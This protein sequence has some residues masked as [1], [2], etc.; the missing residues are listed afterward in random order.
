MGRCCILT[1][2][3]LLTSAMGAYADTLFDAPEEII[4][5]AQSGRVRVTIA[6]PVTQN[7]TSKVCVLYVPAEATDFAF[8]LAGA[9]NALL[10]SWRME[11]TAP[12]ALSDSALHSQRMRLT[13]KIDALRGQIRSTQ[14]TI[15][16]WTTPPTQ[17]LLPKDMDE[18]HNALREHVP[19]AVVAL[20]NYERTLKALEQELATLPEH[21]LT[22]QRITLLLRENA[23]KNITV[24]YAY[25]LP[26][27]GWRP[28]YRI[29]AAHNIID[30]RLDADI[31][32][33]SGMDWHNTRLTLRTEAQAPRAPQALR[34]W[35]IHTE[36]SRPPQRAARMATPQAEP[37]QDMM[38]SADTAPVYTEGAS[39]AGWVIERATLP[40]GTTR[41]PILAELWQDPI[42]RIARPNQTHAPVWIVAKHSFT[43]TALPAGK[44]QY[45]LDNAALGEGH[46]TPEGDTVQ[47]AFGADPLVNVRVAK[48]TRISGASGIINKRQS[49]MWGWHYTVFNQRASAVTV[50]IEEPAPQTTDTAMTSAIQSDPPVQHGENHSLYW[51]VTTPAHGTAEIR[52]TVT[53]TAPQDM[54]LYPGR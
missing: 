3:C 10:L 36:K 40:E 26:R 8:T 28:A 34:P 25:T 12:P 20:A 11:H 31:H 30:V 5:N 39:S 6:A 37:L 52:Y 21:P 41:L 19:L 7:N 49:L 35:I 24:H 32:Q 48:D 27:C 22:V 23:P 9:D 15:A 46:F 16:L 33:Y 54:H 43:G 47:L 45:F 17:A 50:R 13:E 1:L 4:L 38:L 51:N 53:V 18:R 42:Q 29:H 44:A 2:L 14:A